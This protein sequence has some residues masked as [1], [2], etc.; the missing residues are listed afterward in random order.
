MTQMQMPVSQ[1]RELVHTAYVAARNSIALRKESERRNLAA[2]DKQTFWMRWFGPT[3]RSM[4][5]HDYRLVTPTFAQY[6]RIKALTDMT[7]VMDRY[8]VGVISVSPED[9]SLLT[10]SWSKALPEGHA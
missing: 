6:E 10:C 1:F 8:D 5:D 2:W 7:T 9:A 4:V 3:S